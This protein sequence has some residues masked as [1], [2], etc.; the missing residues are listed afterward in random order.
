MDTRNEKGDFAPTVSDEQIIEAWNLD[1]SS[2]RIAK[3]V[4]LS[5]SQVR[6]RLAK[7]REKLS[8]IA[9]D[10]DRESKLRQLLASVPLDGPA[11]SR[12]SA[13]D[14]GLWGVAAKD[15]DGNLVTQG[16]DKLS[17]RYR[18]EPSAP[19]FPLIQPAEP[20]TV[21][22]TPQPFYINHKTWSAFVYSD[23]QIGF[24]QHPETKAITPIHDP[25]ALNVAH[26]I[27]HDVAPKKVVLIGDWMDWP[28]LSRWEQHDE[29]DAVNESIE[30]GHKQLC[31]AR[32]SAPQGAD[33]VMIGSNHGHRPEK[34]IGERNRKA[35]RVRR[36]ADTSTWPVFSEPYLLR[37]E[38]LGIEFSGQYPG[39]EYY[40]L[41]DLVCVHAPPKSKEFAA[42]VIHGHTHK[43]TQDVS[44]THS[45]AGRQTHFTYDTG[46]LCST[47]VTEDK[48]SLVVTTTPSN[49]GRTNWAQGVTVI[50][51]VE[52]KAPIHA[53]ALISIKEGEAQYGGRLYRS[54]LLADE[55]A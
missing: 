51:V 37:F 43:L 16:L 48:Q 23:A 47:G 50:N 38:D 25:D 36:A 41:P 22:F 7:I 17:V 31:K 3:A 33:F 15:A 5:Y 14:V 1:P 54:S 29:F 8:G 6:K 20:K 13:V 4:G 55:A 46:C 27:C 34:W 52:R 39:G 35:M 21:A 12:A 9:G 44:V 10:L 32:S 26:Q 42:S 2:K 19:A 40:L 18:L 45:F 49:Q 28:F 30:E 11:G 24:L 53:V